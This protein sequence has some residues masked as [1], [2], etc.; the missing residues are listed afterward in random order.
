M[1]AAAAVTK[2]PAGR[3]SKRLPPFHAVFPPRFFRENCA[4]LLP[5]QKDALLLINELQGEAWLNDRS[6]SRD[7]VMVRV[8]PAKLA[9]WAGVSER[10]M[11]EAVSSLTKIGGLRQHNLGAGRGCTYA[12]DWDEIA[13]LAKRKLRTVDRSPKVAKTPEPE[14]GGKAVKVDCP[15]GQDCPLEV[16]RKDGELILLTP[17][18]PVAANGLS[19]ETPEPEFGGERKAK[20]APEVAGDLTRKAMADWLHAALPYEKMGGFVPV[21]LEGELWKY[22][23]RVPTWVWMDAIATRRPRIEKW[24]N[25]PRARWT[26]VLK[27]VVEAIQEWKHHGK[28]ERANQ[29]AE[30]AQTAPSCPSCGERRMFDGRCANCGYEVP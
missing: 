21:A 9:A 17:A 26:L 30:A 11:E 19:P 28:P 15:L 3:E 27:I 6:V 24:G 10:A 16:E 12:P 1:S 2:K 25:T 5:T 29:R 20:E 18:S 14:F 8:S 13:K 4:K 23:Q 22:T 7:E